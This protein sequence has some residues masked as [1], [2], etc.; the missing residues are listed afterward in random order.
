MFGG[1]AD[2]E[3]SAYGPYDSQGRGPYMNDEDDYV[4]LPWAV[5][6]AGLYSD[7]RLKI[8]NSDDHSK[9]VICTVADKGPWFNGTDGN[10][11]YVERGTRPLAESLYLAGEP[12]PSGPNKGIVP[13][14]AGIDISPHAAKVIGIDGKGKVDWEWVSDAVA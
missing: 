6:G 5:P 12:C 9:T 4:S 10:D 7:K 11:N 1:D 8:R 2:G 3:Y 13:N 14:G